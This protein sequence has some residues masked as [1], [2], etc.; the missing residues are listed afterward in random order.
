M[1]YFAAAHQTSITKLPEFYKIF[2]TK[3]R[4]LR[5]NEAKITSEKSFNG[6]HFSSEG[7]H[8]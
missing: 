7:N 4:A 8:E 2:Q 3:E 1:Y 6:D 5:V